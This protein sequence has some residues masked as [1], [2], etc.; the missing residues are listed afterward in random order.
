MNIYIWISD[1]TPGNVGN[2][3]ASNNS[4]GFNAEPGGLR[5]GVVDPFV[6]FGVVAIWWPGTP[7]NG[8]A[9]VRFLRNDYSSLYG[10][11]RARK[12]GNSVRCIKD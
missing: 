3:Q 4:S 8:D 5:R 12:T 11:V 1:P 7:Y 10:T 2:D 9:N 6:D